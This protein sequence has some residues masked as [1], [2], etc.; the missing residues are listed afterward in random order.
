M[1]CNLGRG[2]CS[3]S[4]VQ[5]PWDHKHEQDDEGYIFVEYDPYCFNKILSFLRSKAIEHPDH[6][7]PKPVIPSEHKALFNQLVA[8]LGL[9]EFFGQSSRSGLLDQIGLPFCF[10]R[11]ESHKG[12]PGFPGI[13]LSQND[14]VAMFDTGQQAC[15][16]AR[17]V[18]SPAMRPHNIYYLKFEVQSTG[19]NDFIGVS[20]G[21]VG[22]SRTVEYFLEDAGWGQRGR[23][24]S[25]GNFVDSAQW[26]GLQE[27]EQYLMTLTWCQMCCD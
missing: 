15:D 26:G 6:P 16:H 13:V 8:Y 1:D 2:L 24:L 19:A 14:T 9:E 3:C 11:L 22:D 5:W 25:G 17:C 23:V 27:G 4:Q 18:L 7:A 20:A 12:C 10:D 21:R